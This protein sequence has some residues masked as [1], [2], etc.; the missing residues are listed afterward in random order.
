MRRVFELFDGEKILHIGESPG[1]LPTIIYNIF[2]NSMCWISHIS[3]KVLEKLIL[4]FHT[5]TWFT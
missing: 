2:P 4:I 3:N 5:D 1:D